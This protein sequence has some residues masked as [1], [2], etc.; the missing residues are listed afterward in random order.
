MKQ[1]CENCKHGLKIN[2]DW[3]CGLAG[4]CRLWE[5]KEPIYLW[6]PWLNRKLTWQHI[7]PRWDL[8]NGDILIEGAL[9]RGEQQMNTDMRERSR[10]FL[11]SALRELLA[12]EELE[13]HDKN[14]LSGDDCTR[15]EWKQAR[16]KDALRLLNDIYEKE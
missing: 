3:V 11:E 12:V 4:P 2:K 16:L 5:E 14:L 1:N 8:G 6:G 13:Y 10:R 15:S 9:N 7:S